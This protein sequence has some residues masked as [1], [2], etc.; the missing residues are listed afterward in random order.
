MSEAEMDDLFYQIVNGVHMDE[1][2]SVIG[3]HTKYEE[4]E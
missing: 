3:A 4:S 2:E 1:I